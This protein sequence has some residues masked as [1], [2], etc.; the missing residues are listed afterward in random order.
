METINTS[1]GSKPL[2]NKWSKEEDAMLLNLAGESKIKNRWKYVSSVLNTKT[3]KQCFSRYHRINP[4]YKEGK[5]T[6]QEDLRLKEL[7]QLHCKNWSLISKEFMSRSPKQVRDRFLNY[8]NPELV[9]HDFSKEE[10]LIIVNCVHQLGKKWVLISKQLPGRSSY[11]VK[12]RYN[13]M[14]ARVK[15]KNLSSN[16]IATTS[17]SL[18][19]SNSCPKVFQITKMRRYNHNETFVGN[20]LD[21]TECDGNMI[22][23]D[24]HQDFI[25]FGNHDKLPFEDDYY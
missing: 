19:N 20:H 24:H 9:T 3:A 1:V 23:T 8:L 11:S 7:V 5:W 18:S 2:V 12:N 13:L 25:V 10:D 4:L 6:K 14:S 15:Q 21:H 16:T 17:T 22:I